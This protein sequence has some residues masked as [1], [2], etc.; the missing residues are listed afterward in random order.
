MKNKDIETLKQRV[1]KISDKTLTGA[2]S[3][4]SI[5]GRYHTMKNIEELKKKKKKT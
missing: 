3:A 5:E 4:K 1:K 2:K